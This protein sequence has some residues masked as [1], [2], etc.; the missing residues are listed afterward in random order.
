M[1][2]VY[3]KGGGGY[4]QKDNMWIQGCRTDQKGRKKYFTTSSC[5]TYQK[6]PL[7]GVSEE[8]FVLFSYLN[9]FISFCDFYVGTLIF[10]Q[11]F[12]L[13]LG[14]HRSSRSMDLLR[15]RRRQWKWN[16]FWSLVTFTPEKP[17]FKNQIF[18]AK[19]D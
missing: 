9:S 13:S 12:L 11:S 14:E 3:E 17:V 2:W 15:I 18:I 8:Y 4:N 19:L 6:E 5:R 1:R 16:Q 7:N 10:I